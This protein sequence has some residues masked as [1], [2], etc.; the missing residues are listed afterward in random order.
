MTS[1]NLMPTTDVPGTLNEYFVNVGKYPENE[2]ECSRDICVQA[3]LPNSIMLTPAT[4][5]EI[6]KHIKRIRNNIAAGDDD[7]KPLP[8]KYACTLISDILCHIVNKMLESG[9]F[10]N[11]LKIAKV[12]PVHKGG[13]EHTISNYR[14]IYGLPVFSKVF[15][16]VINTRLT[17]FFQKYSY[18]R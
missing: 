4:P 12:T 13:D 18:M 2:E 8:I 3:S 10:P 14:P 16:G 9:T 17:N 5:T 7:L 15:E 1:G 6:E 11:K